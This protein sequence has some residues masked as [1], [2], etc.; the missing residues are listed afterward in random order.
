MKSWRMLS[1][2]TLP[3]VGVI[4]A[5]QV[6]KLARLVAQHAGA[7]LRALPLVQLHVRSWRLQDTS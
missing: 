7:R 6:P 4:L 5:P 1:R 2:V 3:N